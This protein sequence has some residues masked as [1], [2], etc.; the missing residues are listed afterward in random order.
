MLP[1]H[2]CFGNSVATLRSNIHL[3][4]VQGRPLPESVRLAQPSKR[5]RYKIE[6]AGKRGSKCNRQSNAGCR[7]ADTS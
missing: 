3:S 1:A 2:E 5:Q 4:V 7:D 6:Q